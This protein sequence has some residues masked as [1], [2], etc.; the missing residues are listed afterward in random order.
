MAEKCPKCNEKVKNGE[1]IT[2]CPNCKTQYHTWCWNFT[3]KCNICGIENTENYCNKENVVEQ[4]NTEVKSN[5]EDCVNYESTN[6]PKTNVSAGYVQQEHSKKN[7]V[8][9]IVFIILG[10]IMILHSAGRSGGF[11]AFGGDFYT[12]IH[13][14]VSLAVSNLHAIA[15]ILKDGFGFL[16]IG[17]GIDR[18]IK[19]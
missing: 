14:Q 9:G 8:S 10:V 4:N 15:I 11:A 17:L 18:L 2:E 3:E 13:E 6:Q 1:L 7:I 12:E 19:K 5:Q 16:F